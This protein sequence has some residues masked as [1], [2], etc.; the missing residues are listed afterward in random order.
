LY[1]A[2]YISSATIKGKQRAIFAV[3][4]AKLTMIAHDKEHCRW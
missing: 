4:A 3:A 2:S 1:S